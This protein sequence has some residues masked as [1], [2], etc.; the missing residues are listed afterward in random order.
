MR[1]PHDLTG[2]GARGHITGTLL[3]NAFYL[4]ILSF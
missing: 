1:N 3:W 4:F 2:L